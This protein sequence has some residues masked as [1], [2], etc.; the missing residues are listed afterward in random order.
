M[1]LK[2]TKIVAAVNN[3]LGLRNRRTNRSRTS[4][5]PSQVQSG[6]AQFNAAGPPILAASPGAMYQPR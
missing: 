6:T 3:A 4:A 5:T 2:K 1:P